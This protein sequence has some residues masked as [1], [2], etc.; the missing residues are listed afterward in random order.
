MIGNYPNTERSQAVGSNNGNQNNDQNNATPDG[1]ALPKSIQRLNLLLDPSKAEE[2]EKTVKEARESY[3]DDFGNMDL[4]STYP[5]VFQLLWY[6]QLPCFDVKDVTS[7]WPDQMSIIKSC[8]WKGKK[9]SC[10]SIFKM[11]PTDRGMCCTFNM[12]KAEE[13]FQETKYAEL[14]QKFQNSDQEKRY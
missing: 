3:D 8:S 1:S 12:K 13:I 2:R 9:I 7:N 11:L 14:V 4:N 6:S 10:P 5:S